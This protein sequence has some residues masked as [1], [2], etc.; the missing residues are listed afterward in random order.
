MRAVAPSAPVHKAG[1]LATGTMRILMSGLPGV[2]SLSV[3]SPD[4]LYSV[5]GY[6]PPSINR[7]WPVMKP[8]WAEHR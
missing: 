5:P 4:V 2:S 7:F 1:C 8:A 3:V 6:F